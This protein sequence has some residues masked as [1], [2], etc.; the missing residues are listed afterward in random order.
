MKI[1]KSILTLT[2]LFITSFAYSM[3]VTNDSGS[4][5]LLAAQAF[6][7]SLNAEQ[8]NKAIFD[9][10]NEERVHWDFVPLQDAKTRTYTRK[11]L[12]LEEMN[13][14]QKKAAF[15]LLKASTSKLGLKTIQV[16]IYQE[17]MLLEHEK[18]MGEMIRNPGWYFFSIFGTPSKTGKWG[19]RFEGHHV[20]MNFTLEGTHVISCTP[21]F[22]GVNPA[23]VKE[24]PSKGTRFLPEMEDY[25]RALFKSL[26]TKQKELAYQF[27]HFDDPGE[28]PKTEN[29][30]EFKYL[31]RTKSPLVGNPIGVPVSQM[32]D[33]QQNLLKALFKAYIQYFPDDIA[34]V[35]QDY[36]N[37]NNFDFNETYFAF[38]GSPE[39]GEAYT[40]RIQGPQ[41]LIE[42]RNI[43][44]DALGNKNNHIHSCLRHIKGD[45]GLSN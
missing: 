42:F 25:A 45:F 11:G 36:F 29:R 33:Y 44:E 23:E 24:G 30:S 6:I 20:S 4:R 39:I 32:S 5:M 1:N 12:P 37:H 16:I 40:Y 18:G 35:E 2:T 43:Q 9:F 14:N 28:N 21:N 27:K 10:G 15:E 38:S 34:K 3:Q 7:A 26:N 13:M 31:P 8:K 19:W 22:L 41:I 17:A